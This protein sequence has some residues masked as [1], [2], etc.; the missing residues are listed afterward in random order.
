M[1]TSTRYQQSLCDEVLSQHAAIRQA[2]QE[3]VACARRVQRGDATTELTRRVQHLVRML[4]AHLEFEERT[5]LPLLRAVDAHGRRQGAR[6][7]AEHKRQR[8]DLA[9]IEAQV[10]GGADDGDPA[11]V[12]AAIQAFLEDLLADM[13]AEEGPLRDLE[14]SWDRAAAR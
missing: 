11:A 7:V 8:A 10:L 13:L 3:T 12:A 4:L 1:S 6:M 14:A 9:T 5:L 2:S